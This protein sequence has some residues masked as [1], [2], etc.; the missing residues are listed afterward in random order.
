MNLQFTLKPQGPV[1]RQ[2]SVFAGYR[3]KCQH[4]RSVLAA[5]IAGATSI[6]SFATRIVA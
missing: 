2:H 1:R 3:P 4:S 5:M 6:S